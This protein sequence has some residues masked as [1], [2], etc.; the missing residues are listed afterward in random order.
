M[1]FNIGVPFTSINISPEIRLYKRRHDYSAIDEMFMAFVIE[2]PLSS[3]KRRRSYI[4]INENH[5]IEVSFAVANVLNIRLDTLDWFP[6][7]TI[8]LDIV[9]IY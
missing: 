1:E 7:M 4:L 9:S 5:L 3:E 6:P 2:Y 8:S